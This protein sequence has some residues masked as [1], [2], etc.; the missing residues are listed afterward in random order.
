MFRFS[1]TKSILLYFRKLFCLNY[2][3]H[4]PNANGL[5]DLDEGLLHLI[6]KQNENFNISVAL[7]KQTKNPI[8]FLPYLKIG[9]VDYRNL[10]IPESNTLSYVCRFLY[11]KC[12]KNYTCDE[13]I[14]YSQNDLDKSFL[15]CYSKVHEDKIKTI[16]G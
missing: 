10:N 5:K 14:K 3:Q 15:L 7:P 4:L 13:C 8:N 12:L 2:F 16:F 6:P 9:D 1:N 11:N